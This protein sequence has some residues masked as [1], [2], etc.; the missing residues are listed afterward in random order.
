MTKLGFLA[1]ALAAIGILATAIG[2]AGSTVSGSCGPQVQILDPGLRA[3]F[4][5]FE[6]GQSGTAAKICALYRDATEF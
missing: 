1:L 3:S 5:K 6:A 4:A 2:P